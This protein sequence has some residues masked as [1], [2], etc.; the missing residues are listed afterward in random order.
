M[1][2][3]ITILAVLLLLSTTAFAA[4]Y[5]SQVSYNLNNGI[6]EVRKPMRCRWMKSRPHRR[7]KVLSRSKQQS[8]RT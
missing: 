8:L 6:F 5:P 1:K 7:S 2:K 4:E 3:P